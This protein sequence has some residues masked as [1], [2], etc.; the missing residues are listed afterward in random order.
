M[1]NHEQGDKV[2]DDALQQL[3]GW[4]N[5]DTRL[6]RELPI[7]ESQHAALKERIKIVSDT[8]GVRPD[9]TRQ[10]GVTLIELSRPDG[11]NANDVTFAGRVED[12]YRVIAGDA[13][14]DHEASLPRQGSRL[15]RW[16][17]RAV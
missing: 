11:V 17:K 4:V 9:V 1:A 10:S 6:C 8:L 16:F 7:D 14:G 5:D 3:R 13:F 15:G 2:L 12:A